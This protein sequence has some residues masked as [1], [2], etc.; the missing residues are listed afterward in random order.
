MLGDSMDQYNLD[1]RDADLKKLAQESLQNRDL[2]IK[3]KN[4]IRSREKTVRTN[5]LNVLMI[6]SENNGEFLYPDWEYF[7][8][9][10]K[11][12]NAYDQYVA[13][14]LLASLT[15]VDKD[16]KFESIFDEYYGILE[17]DKTLTASHVVLNSALIASNK[18]ELR[19][20]IIER[21]INTDNT[22]NGMQKDLIKVYAIET[23]RK[24]K[25]EGEEKSTIEK[26][27]KSQLKN[28]SSRTRSAAKCY[29]DRCELD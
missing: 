22:F 15:A 4:G 25:V 20:M 27:V 3:L 1:S 9:M 18:P 17:G 23:L 26:F 16:K 12:T 7:H 29:I 24:I 19:S 8:E 6:L 2:F 13:I 21:L 5:S 14:Y 10:L 28:S 11:S